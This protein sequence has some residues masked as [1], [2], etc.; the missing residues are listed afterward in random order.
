MAQ[1]ANKLS[2]EMKRMK[3]EKTKG[4]RVEYENEGNLFKQTGYIDG[5]KDSP[6]EHGV[7]ELSIHVPPD[8]PFRAP[9][10]KFKTPVF[11]PNINDSGS[12]CVDILKDQWAPVLTIKSVLLS[13]QTLLDDPNPKDPLDPS[14]AKLFTEDLEAYKKKVTE[15]T[16]TYAVPKDKK[17]EEEVK[18]H[19]KDLIKKEDETPLVP[20]PSEDANAEE[21]QLIEEDDDE[22]DN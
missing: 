15:Y 4:I 14:A 18:R 21:I 3:L 22:E 1:A 5:P 6:F 20:E 2:H 13:I 8:Y 16:W 11:H 10:V 9:D 19:F 12:I 7:F 17:S